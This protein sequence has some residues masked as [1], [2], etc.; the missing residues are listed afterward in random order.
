MSSRIVVVAALLFLTPAVA[1]A[2]ATAPPDVVDRVMAVVGDSIILESEVQEQLQ[3]RAA[4]GRAIPT[5]P[6]ALA[7]V[8]RQELEG[9]VN[10]MLLLQ[11]AKRDSIIILP[12]ELRSQ[13]DATIAE[14][15]RRFGGRAA[16][17]QA[18]LREG[19]T[20]EQYRRTVEQGML[21]TG[22]QQRYLATLQ[23]DRPPPPVSDAELRTFFAE[24]VADLGPR[25]A[26]IVFEQV[27]VTPRAS[28]QAR[29]EAQAEAEQVREQL[30]AGEDFALLA[31]RYS[32][33]AATRERGGELGWFRRGRMVPEFERAAFSL[34]PGAIS[35]VVESSFGF[36]IIRVDR[37]RGAE[38][39]ARHILIRPDITPAE[40][41]R[42]RERAE[43]AAAALREGVAP[44]SVRRMVHH[45]P[46]QPGMD[47]HVGPVPLDTL[48]Q[49]YRAQLIDAE[50]GQ[51]VG[52]FRVPGPGET[53]AVVQML[54]RL[55]EGEYDL[56][57]PGLRD[58]VR[59]HLQQEKLM[60]EVLAELRRRT[61]IDIRY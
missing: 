7:Q 45:D 6:D 8:R 46:E 35:P 21:R 32:A 43:S 17:E 59:R 58:Q 11:A 41:A 36:H 61:Y 34:R 14:Q 44:D 55:P 12:D 5:E 13:V 9:L 15:E 16:F 31:R 22:M 38:R 19:L 40:E 60:E 56:D 29:A 24:N 39:Q 1:R 4:F 10:E 30:L 2:Q 33:D 54:D 53:F 52:P 20:P 51:V 37:V 48:P 23:R 47:G 27:L 25:P 49:V 26:S 3:R 28:D 50:P 18:L 57:E 42:T